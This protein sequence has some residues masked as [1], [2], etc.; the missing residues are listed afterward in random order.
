MLFEN[1]CVNVEIGTTPKSSE[2]S[3]DSK[4]GLLWDE[5]LKNENTR[6]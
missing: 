1:S 3:A 5:L 2:V 4:E 6:I